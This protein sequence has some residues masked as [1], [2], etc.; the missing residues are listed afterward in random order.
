MFREFKKLFEKK[1]LLDI[2]L[3]HS[4]QMLI[5]VKEMY[6]M[7]VPALRQTDAPCNPQEIQKRDKVINRYERQVRRDVYI[8]MVMSD[9][10]DRYTS[11]VLL[12][13]VIDIER[14]GD[15]TKN[16]VELAT[17]Y[18]ARLTGGRIEKELERLEQGVGDFLG[19]VH[20]L[21]RDSDDEMA[22]QLLEKYSE[23]GQTIDAHV[24]DLIQ[25]SECDLALI[26]VAALASYLRVLNRINAHCITIATAVVNPFDRIGFHHDLCCFC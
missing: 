9:N 19:K 3:E 13:I 12:N 26:L 4:L 6:D 7:A 1:S 23:V 22:V 14:I 20:A 2:A 18:P 8:H 11:L 21:F 16:I 15:Y 17:W 10:P 5:D 25:C 24:G